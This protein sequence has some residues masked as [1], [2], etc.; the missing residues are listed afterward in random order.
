MRRTTTALAMLCS[1]AILGVGACSKPASPPPPAAVEF[2][3]EEM[4][5][6]GL[7][8]VQT[9]R[10]HQIFLKPGTNMSDFDSILVDSFMISYTNPRGAPEGPVRT[11]DEETEK[12]LITLM[13]DMFIDQMG[14]S[15]G[16][17]LVEEPGPRTIRVQG[18]LYDIV[19]E[20]PPRE[21]SRN[22]PLCFAEMKAILTVRKSETA[23]PLARVVDEV[24]LSCAARKRA[25]FQSAQWKD[26]EN[27]A[28]KP[29]A[30]FLRDW[31]EE[32]RELPADS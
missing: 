29:W 24:K 19:V 15:K 8:L 7:R 11:L 28:L 26:V 4:T 16:F 25:R 9:T 21:D 23:E 1:L 5:D 10:G 17:D 32:L 20:E 30:S 3:S 18:W 2:E 31:L 12:R 13:R 6:D 27:A 14:R 22:F